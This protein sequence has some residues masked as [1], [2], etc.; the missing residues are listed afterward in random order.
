MF[1]LQFRCEVNREHGRRQDFAVWG[2][3]GGRAKGIGEATGH[4]SLA[5]S[6]LEACGGIWGQG[7]EH[8]GQLPHIPAGAAHDREETSRMAILQ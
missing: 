5:S 2:K 6:Y 1:H 8:R 4:M 3:R 7:R